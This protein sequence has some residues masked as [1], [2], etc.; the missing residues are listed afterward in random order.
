VNT[1]DW[2]TAA[3]AAAIVAGSALVIW[4]ADPLADRI[5]KLWRRKPAKPITARHRL[6]GPTQVIDPAIFAKAL[7]QARVD[8]AQPA[9]WPTNPD[10][11]ERTTRW[12]KWL[13]T[14]AV[15]A[16]RWGKR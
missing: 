6:D 16:S 7:G 8:A 15:V 2:A 3:V 5:A 13:P 14:N 1:A 10:R 11:M 12:I 9:D 4:K